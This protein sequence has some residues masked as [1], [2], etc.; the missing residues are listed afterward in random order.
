MRSTRAPALSPPATSRAS[1]RKTAVACSREQSGTCEATRE[2]E[3]EQCGVV[4]GAKEDGLL[5][6]LHPLLARGENSFTHLARLLV[7]VPGE[8]ELGREAAVPLG[9]Q[10]L[11][12]ALAIL[13]RDRV[14]HGEDR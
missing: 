11:G 1:A 6:Q 8:A 5:A 9:P 10:P 3:L 14:G 4:A 13:L 12:K 7:L 2:L